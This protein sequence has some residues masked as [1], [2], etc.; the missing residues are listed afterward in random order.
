M[1]AEAT[2]DTARLLQDIRSRER[3]RGR[4]DFQRVAV[5][6]AMATGLVLV[7]WVAVKAGLGL[8]DV[9]K[10]LQDP[11]GA[12]EDSARGIAIAEQRRRIEVLKKQGKK[13]VR[14]MGGPQG[15]RTVEQ[16]D[17]VV[18]VALGEAQ[19]ELDRLLAED[20]EVKAVSPE[21]PGIG[22]LKQVNQVLDKW[23]PVAPAA[24]TGGTILLEIL[25]IRRERRLNEY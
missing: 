21:S 12:A 2:L 13:R 25:R 7:S 11:V 1:M 4:F 24:I 23:L 14:V 19:S 9:T 17:P 3:E 22:E 10:A 18:M 20:I 6:S 15:I 5:D 16:D 8:Y